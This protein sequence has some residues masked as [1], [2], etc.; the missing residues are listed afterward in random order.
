MP[1]L[2]DRLIRLAHA[3][4]ELRPHLVAILREAAHGDPYWFT[5]KYPGKTVDGVSFGKGDKVLYWPRTKQFMVGD[6]AEQAW[7]DF[8]AQVADEDAYNFRGAGERSAARNLWNFEDVAAAVADARAHAKRGHWALAIRE[9][10]DLKY[11]PDDTLGRLATALEAA[12]DDASYDGDK[13][14]AFA[15]LDKIEEYVVR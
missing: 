8:Q 13:R 15:L 9:I 4:P 3:D 14:N 2:R 11:S 12:L 10:H 5:A 6:K 7:R 1:D